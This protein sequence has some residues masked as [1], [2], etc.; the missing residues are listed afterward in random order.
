VW[1]EHESTVGVSAGSVH[2]SLSP[3]ASG[4]LLNFRIASS[5]RVPVERVAHGSEGWIIPTTTI[6]WQL[7]YD[8]GICASQKLEMADCEPA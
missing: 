3:A 4:V 8:L 7:V 6:G 1:S 2:A 5:R